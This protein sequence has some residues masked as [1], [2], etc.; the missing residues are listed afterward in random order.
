MAIIGWPSKVK[1]RQFKKL[2]KRPI[3]AE[4]DAHIK[5]RYG[6][7]KNKKFRPVSGKDGWRL[8]NINLKLSLIPSQT[9]VVKGLQSDK[10]LNHEQGHWDILGLLAR[11][12]HTDLEAIRA[13]S[14][15]KLADMVEEAQR[16]MDAK[17]ERIG[18]NEGRY[19]TETNHGLKDKEQKTWD[20]L[21][22]KCITNGKKLPNN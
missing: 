11:E 5:G 12:L 10:L 4:T 3:A 19:D 7:P 13:P 15:K 16:N 22:E 21:I 20:N 2:K 14:L 6:N 1:W 17:A 9:W 8:K 18:G